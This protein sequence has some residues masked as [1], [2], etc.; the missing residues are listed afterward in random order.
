[1]RLRGDKDNAGRVVVVVGSINVDFTVRVPTLP[2]AGE[3]VL[4]TDFHFECGGKGANQAIASARA[5]AETYFVGAV[6]ADTL[7]MELEADL[8]SAG[9]KTAF[10][11]KVPGC[12]SGMA[13]ITVDAS[14]DNQIAVAPGANWHLSEG[15]VRTALESVNAH[16]KGGLVVLASLEVNDECVAA[17]ASMAQERSW[18]FVL[19]PA[20]FRRLSPS[21]LSHVDVLTPNQME[22]ASLLSQTSPVDWV[23]GK[24]PVFSEV[25]SI[26]EGK[27]LV[28]TLGSV[29]A[30]L[31][32]AAGRL[33]IPA[34]SVEVVD[35]TGAGD[36][37]NGVLAAALADGASLAD[38]VQRGVLAGS[39]AATWIGAHHARV[40][41]TE[42]VASESGPS[43]WTRGAL[44][45]DHLGVVD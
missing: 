41:D 4:G 3:T 25:F 29:G 6:G 20:P 35:S 14:G 15:H 18:G 5:G 9:V 30:V 7:G 33:H 2:H 32:T 38:A 8:A 36:A 1:M 40:D 22:A 34:P 31:I 28:V 27:G 37:F 42:M 16:T 39:L 19:N 24:V 23:T 17:A 45:L 26:T 11:A 10:L 13:L 21:L 43:G 44:R 12:A